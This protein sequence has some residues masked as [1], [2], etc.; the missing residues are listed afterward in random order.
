[1]RV[2]LTG[3]TGYLGQAVGRALLVAGHD[4]M[5]LV[6]NDVGRKTVAAAGMN[7]LRGDLDDTAALA[8]PP[9]T[10]T[11]SSRWPVPTTGKRLGTSKGFAKPGW[12]P[13]TS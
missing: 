10:S 3:A 12:A 8:M 11:R 1:M 6:R 2:L 4:V 5:G 7:T 9:A 13:R